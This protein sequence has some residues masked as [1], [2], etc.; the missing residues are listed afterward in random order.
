MGEG[1]K[2]GELAESSTFIRF[3][4]DERLTTERTFC[5]IYRPIPP[6]R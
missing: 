6:C 1:L 5:I 3:F 4:L 2:T